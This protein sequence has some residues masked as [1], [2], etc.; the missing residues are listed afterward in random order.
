MVLTFTVFV[1][2]SYYMIETEQ[3]KLKKEVSAT[4]SDKVMV[5]PGGMPIGIY[6]ETDGVMVLG[7]D[8]VKGIDGMSYNPS[9]NLVHP[10]DYITEIDGHKV[11]S[12]A[13]LI[14]EI[15]KIKKEK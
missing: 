2:G 3:G 4:A 8:E 1:G 14:R 6:L 11:D 15:K 10:G 13:E 7:T 9:K 12:K 5:I